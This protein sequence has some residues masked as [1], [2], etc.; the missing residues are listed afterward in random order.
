[1]ARAEPGLRAR[2]FP[3]RGSR[4]DTSVNGALRAYSSRNAAGPVRGAVV[5]DDH[6]EGPRYPGAGDRVETALEAGAPIARGDEQ[7]DPHDATGTGCPRA[8]PRLRYS[9]RHPSR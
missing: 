3:G 1:M 5:H 6:L 8:A 4:R 2:D 9:Y 7:G